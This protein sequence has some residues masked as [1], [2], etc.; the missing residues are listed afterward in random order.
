MND[1]DSLF[2]FVA[3]TSICS[4]IE[5]HEASCIT[6]GV[7]CISVDLACSS[8]LLLKSYDVTSDKGL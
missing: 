1:K 2:V 5:M 8:N 7:E 6:E 3:T 4:F